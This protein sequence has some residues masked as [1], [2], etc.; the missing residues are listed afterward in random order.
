MIKRFVLAVITVFVV[1]SVLDFVIHGIIL[2]S[3]YQATAQLW[4]P[5]GEMKMGL[6]YLFKLV[7]AGCFVGIY[8]LFV[9]PKT[10]SKGLGYGLIFG[11]GGGIS[12]GLGTYSVMPVP[13]HLCLVWYLGFVIETVVGGLLLASIVKEPK[14]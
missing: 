2:Q 4:R 13:L 9:Q 5:M 8:A 11:L 6:M 12:M 1:W 7:A 3:T 14:I 10:F